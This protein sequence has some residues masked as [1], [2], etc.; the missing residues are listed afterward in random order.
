M[1]STIDLFGGNHA[2]YRVLFRA[3]LD[4]WRICKLGIIVTTSGL[5][6]VVERHGLKW[7][8]ALG[9]VR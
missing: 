8:L 5:G 1:A 9:R 4:V 2:P 6:I 3:S 7:A